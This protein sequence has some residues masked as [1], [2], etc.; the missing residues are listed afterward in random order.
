MPDGPDCATRSI[1]PNGIGQPL[2]KAAA[3]TTDLS[4]KS[5]TRLSNG[6]LDKAP[7]L[8]TAYLPPA[9]QHHNN[10]V[11]LP[12]MSRK[13]AVLLLSSPSTPNNLPNQHP[14][15]HFRHKNSWHNSFPPT[16]IIKVW[17]NYGVGNGGIITVARIC[18]R[19][20]PSPHN[21]LNSNNL[22][23][24]S[25]RRGLYPGHAHNKPLTAKSL[26]RR[27]LPWAPT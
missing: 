9:R 11:V 13:S 12:S 7:M 8:F 26:P 14:I 23:L 15:N 24:S 21:R 19:L 10:P 18:G 17:G 27:T 22:Q 2:K 6:L 20:T 1:F 25:S 3:V 5:G 4:T 16:R